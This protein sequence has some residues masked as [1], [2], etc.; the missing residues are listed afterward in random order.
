MDPAAGG[1]WI[2]ATTRS[3]LLFR[4]RPALPA[5]VLV[6]LHSLNMFHAYGLPGRGVRYPARHRIS[7]I[8]HHLR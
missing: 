2:R 5:Q 4:P 7:V 8:H 3:N 6:T 1:T